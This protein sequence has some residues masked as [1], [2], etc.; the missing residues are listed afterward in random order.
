VL[1]ALITYFSPLRR[2]D[3]RETEEALA[4]IEPA[5]ESEPAPAD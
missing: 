4:E 1:A 3:I 2:Y 5:A